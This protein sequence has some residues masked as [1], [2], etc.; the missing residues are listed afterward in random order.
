[1]AVFLFF[2]LLRKYDTKLLE[3]SSKV[4]IDRDAKVAT[5]SLASL[6]SVGGKDRHITI[7]GDAYNLIKSTKVHKWS[8]GSMNPPY[9]SIIGYLKPFG[10][11]IAVISEGKGVFL[12]TICRCLS[13]LF[14]NVS[15]IPGP[16]F[17]SIPR[18]R[19]IMGHETCGGMTSWDLWSTIVCR[20]IGRA[21]AWF[22]WDDCPRVSCRG[23]SGG[24]WDG[25]TTLYVWLCKRIIIATNWVSRRLNWLCVT[26]WGYAC[27]SWPLATDSDFVVFPT[28]CISLLVYLLDMT[29]MLRDVFHRQHQWNSLDTTSYLPGEGKWCLY[30]SSN[31]V[32]K[33]L[34]LLFRFTSS[35][36][37]SNCL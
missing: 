19:S 10:R 30:F 5:Q 2:L 24:L 26:Y 17:S 14:N 15:S 25:L 11:E 22:S 36:R 6:L 32:K 29:F 33:R 12:K 4:L 8:S 16:L 9:S 13:F 27:R 37:I 18:S 7:S 23:I 1:M 28:K 31:P 3:S 35:M 34:G 20:I 21:I